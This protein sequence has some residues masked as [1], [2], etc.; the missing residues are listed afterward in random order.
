MTSDV[1]V[2]AVRHTVCCSMHRLN[3][4]TRISGVG[5]RAKSVQLTVTSY[6]WPCVFAWIPCPSG[7]SSGSCKQGD[8]VSSCALCEVIGMIRARNWES[9]AYGFTQRQQ[10]L[11]C[12]WKLLAQDGKATSADNMN[13]LGYVYGK[14]PNAWLTTAPKSPKLIHVA[15]YKTS[16]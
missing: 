1:G 5:Q 2:R 15:V 10:S 7:E 11:L 3:T 16:Q 6:A 9:I 13:R 12:F 4:V 14:Q 8:Q